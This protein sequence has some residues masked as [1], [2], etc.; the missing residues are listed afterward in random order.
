MLGENIKFNNV[1]LNALAWF[2][3]LE[4]L[5]MNK[6]AE[7]KALIVSTVDCFKLL[8]LLF[9]IVLSHAIQSPSDS[10]RRFHFFY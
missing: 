9:I 2:M 5:I 6:I 1:S 3:L 10:K 8:Y 4:V 7:M